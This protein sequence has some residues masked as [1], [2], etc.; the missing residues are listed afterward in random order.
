M[1]DLNIQFDGWSLAANGDLQEARVNVGVPIRTTSGGSVH[2]FAGSATQGRYEGRRITVAGTIGGTSQSDLRDSFSLILEQLGGVDGNR[3][4]RL[5][6]YGDGYYWAQLEGS[7]TLTPTGPATASLLIQF[8]AADPWRRASSL[9][10]KTATPTSPNFEIS[11][12]HGLDFSG[13][14]PR[15]PLR[16][17]LGQGWQKDELV[18]IESTTVGWV[19]EHVVTQDLTGKTLFIDGDDHEVLEDGVAVYEAVSGAF[20]W[21]IGSTGNTLDFTGCDR[22]QSFTLEFWDRYFA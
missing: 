4:G 22:K 7:P 17:N 5:D 21:I 3:F 16:I 9:V 20:P 10:T 11:L 8:F 14:A 19:F 12:T 2:P 15:I 13:N 1:A 18:R 6:L